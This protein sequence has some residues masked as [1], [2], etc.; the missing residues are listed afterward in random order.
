MQHAVA[1]ACLQDQQ[2]S[3]AGIPYATDKLTPW[4]WLAAVS[5][6]I[7]VHGPCQHQRTFWRRCAAPG[8]IAVRIAASF[9]TRA[10]KV[11]GPECTRS[12]ANATNSCRPH[13]MSF[14]LAVHWWCSPDVAIRIVAD[15]DLIIGCLPISNPNRRALQRHSRRRILSKAMLAIS[16]CCFCH[17]SSSKMRLK[18]VTLSQQQMWL[19]K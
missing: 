11:S 7:W 5:L 17:S 18:Q 2:H 8:T 13:A 15:L 14:L 3:I 12:D 19:R 9:P 16:S 1:G 4:V 6:H 10:K